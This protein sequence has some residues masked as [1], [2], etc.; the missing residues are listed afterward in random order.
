MSIRNLTIAT[1]G[2]AQDLFPAFHGVGGF[3]ITPLDEDMWIQFGANAAVDSGEKIFQNSGSKFTYDQYPELNARVSVFSAT[4]GAK[5]TL[6]YI[7]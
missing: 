6:R 4:A 3:I 2:A 5:F 1:G 7:S